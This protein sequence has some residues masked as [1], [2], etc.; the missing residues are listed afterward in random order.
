[1]VRNIQEEKDS[2]RGARRRGK[3]KGLGK[4][5]IPPRPFVY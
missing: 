2:I 5:Q 3:E 4:G 1:L